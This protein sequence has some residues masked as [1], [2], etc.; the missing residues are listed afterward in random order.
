MTGGSAVGVARAPGSAAA[1][2]RCGWGGCSARLEVVGCARPG[3]G[4]RWRYRPVALRWRV[5]LRCRWGRVRTGSGR[6]SV[7]RA[8]HPAQPPPAGR[9]GLPGNL[10][11]SP[12]KAVTLL[13]G[14]FSHFAFAQPLPLDANRNGALAGMLDRIDG[15]LTACFS[16]HDSA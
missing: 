14:A 11:P 9:A 10:D 4:S 2:V 16:S 8:E 15:P 5:R 12:V 7:S 3:R 1:E 13:Q 6:G